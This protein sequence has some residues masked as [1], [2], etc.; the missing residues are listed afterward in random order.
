MNPYLNYNNKKLN[1]NIYIFG[2]AGKENI[3]SETISS[4]TDVYRYSPSE[5]KWEKIDTSSPYGL[6]GHA[7]VSIS[8]NKAIILGGVN[9]QIFDKYFINLNHAKNNS[10]NYLNLLLD[11][12]MRLSH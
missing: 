4:L 6:V 3:E 10:L 11:Y 5:D 9:K 12:S 8:T 1:N 7:G 2:G